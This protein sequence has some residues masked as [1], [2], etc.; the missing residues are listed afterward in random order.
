V[1]NHEE[2]RPRVLLAHRNEISQILKKQE[3]KGARKSA[4]L[5][6]YMEKYTKKKKTSA[7]TEGRH[8]RASSHLFQ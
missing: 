2:R 7:G 5:W 6:L 8:V 1:F 4:L 3:Q